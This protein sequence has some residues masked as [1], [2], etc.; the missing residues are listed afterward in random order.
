MSRFAG[1][2]LP[3]EAKQAL[4][5]LPTIDVAGFVIVLEALVSHISGATIASSEVARS[6]QRA[7]SLDMG[8][9]GTL[10]TGLDW[11]LRTCMRSSLKPKLLHAELTDVRVHPP[12]IEP[13]VQAVERR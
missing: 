2:E 11:L 12:C 5:V 6:L 7:T 10:F 4:R 13:I 3:F 1:A 8:A 9:L